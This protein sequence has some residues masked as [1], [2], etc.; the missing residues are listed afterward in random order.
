MLRITKQQRTELT[1]P[2]VRQVA[3]YVANEVLVAMEKALANQTDAAS[4]PISG[5]GGSLER[6]CQSYFQSVS[7]V[8]QQAAVKKVMSSVNAS[9]EQRRRVYGELAKINL[10]SRDAVETQVQALALPRLQLTKD[11]LPGSH[12]HT[13]PK[14]HHGGAHE[15]GVID[16]VDVMVINGAVN[17]AHH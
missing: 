4:Y 6:V 17:M 8:R 1:N 12:G 3:T 5:N 11:D 15:P 2:K 14:A 10:R 9:P 16:I 13:A 7:P